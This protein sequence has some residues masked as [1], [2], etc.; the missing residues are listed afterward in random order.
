MSNVEK[1]DPESYTMRQAR[2]MSKLARLPG[3]RGVS[4]MELFSLAVDEGTTAEVTQKANEII[5]R[6]FCIYQLDV[7]SYKKGT[8]EQV[9][10]STTGS[11]PFEEKKK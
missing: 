8:T 1:K 4:F 11:Y 6:E 10:H 7:K 5:E 9:E 3:V 2:V